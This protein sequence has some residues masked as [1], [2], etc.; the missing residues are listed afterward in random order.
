LQRLARGGNPFRVAPVERISEMLLGES[1]RLGANI[2]LSICRR[3]PWS[4]LIKAGE[5][6]APKPAPEFTTAFLSRI[7]NKLK[8][9]AAPSYP[10]VIALFDY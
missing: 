5:F 9:F 8:K 7:Y 2:M 10:P 3:S 1:R 6:V 4:G